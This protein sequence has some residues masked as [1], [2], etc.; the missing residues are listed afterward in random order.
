MVGLVAAAVAAKSIRRLVV[1]G[2]GQTV[3][4][5]L[6]RPVMGLI[7]LP[8]HTKCPNLRIRIR[9]YRIG[10]QNPNIHIRTSFL[11]QYT[12]S[13]PNMYIRT[14]QSEYTQ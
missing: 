11:S 7:S 13:D 3:P 6:T 2:A 9:I 1:G 12:Y 8:L 10:S 14:A 5:M 4:K